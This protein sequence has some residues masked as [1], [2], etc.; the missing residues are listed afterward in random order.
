[1]DHALRVLIKNVLKRLAPQSLNDSP[2]PET[3]W[4]LVKPT[5]NA[6]PHTLNH[7]SFALRLRLSSAFSMT[8]LR[9]YGKRMDKEQ[10]GLTW[11]LFELPSLTCNR[12]LHE[13][14]FNC[15]LMTATI[16]THTHTHTHAVNNCTQWRTKQAKCDA[17]K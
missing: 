4:P 8:L 6:C 15:I 16:T 14:H 13:L 10:I 12:C 3:G 9:F 1:V 7:L 11:E 5:P 17:L 2:E